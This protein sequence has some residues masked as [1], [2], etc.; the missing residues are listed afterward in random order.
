MYILLHLFDNME[1]I[2]LNDNLFYI[3]P[4]DEIYNEILEIA[5]EIWSTYDDTHGYASGKIAYISSIGN[6]GSNFMTIYWMFDCINQQKLVDKA[7][8]EL[9]IEIFIRL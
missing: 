6:I 9:K 3:A 4:R 5:K 8:K 7:S 1:T 2:T